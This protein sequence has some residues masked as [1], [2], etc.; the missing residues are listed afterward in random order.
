[1]KWYLGSCLGAQAPWPPTCLDFRPEVLIIQVS[2][3]FTGN[4]TSDDKL[5]WSTNPGRYYVH[6]SIDYSN[7]VITIPEGR[8]YFIYA[9]VHFNI[10][11]KKPNDQK[12]FVRP[13]R[14]TIRVCKTV[15]GYEQTLLGRSKLFNVTKYGNVVG[16]LR[17]ETL[18]HLTRNDQIYVRVND[19]STVI[20]YSTGTTFGIFPLWHLNIHVSNNTQ[21]LKY[22][23]LDNV[24]FFRE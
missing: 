10:T 5:Y 3:Y 4:Q 19:A 18:L 13:Q 9:S 24:S 11:Q 7:G 17:V 6:D 1:M 12:G 20:P 2:T 16:S 22:K 8:D 15:Y 21:T 23:T 14:I